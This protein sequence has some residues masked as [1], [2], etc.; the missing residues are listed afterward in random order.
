MNEA[1]R[2]KLITRVRVVAS[3]L[4]ITLASIVGGRRKEEAEYKGK[5]NGYQ[6]TG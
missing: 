6:E 4:G 5:F 2:L 1:Q 3:R